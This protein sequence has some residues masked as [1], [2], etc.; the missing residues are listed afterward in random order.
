[1]RPD[2]ARRQLTPAAAGSDCAR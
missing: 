2:Q 1:M